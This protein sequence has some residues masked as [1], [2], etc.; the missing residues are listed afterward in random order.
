MADL[1]EI[2]RDFSGGFLRFLE[3]FFPGFCRI[4]SEILSVNEGMIEE[5]FQDFSGF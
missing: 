3:G 5:D 1:V 4:L 2:F